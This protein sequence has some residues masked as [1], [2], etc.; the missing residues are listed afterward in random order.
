M[1]NFFIPVI[2]TTGLFAQSAGV[3]SPT[4]STLPTPAQL[5]ARE[6]QTAARF[7]R[8]DSAQT[9]ALTGN[10]TLTGELETTEATLQTNASTLKTDYG[11]LATQLISSPSSAPAAESSILT[12]IEAD[13]PLRV[14]LAGQI[15]SALQALSGNLALTSQQ[16]A[17][18][19]ALVA[20]LAGRGG[21]G[22]F[23]GRH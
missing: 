10:T 3:S 16:T 9:S 4:N 12:L 2:L 5:A 8:L 23:G 21:A 18:L 6:L 1:K 14:T 13:F 19:P 20:V 7:L 17:K 22:P 11:T 15:I